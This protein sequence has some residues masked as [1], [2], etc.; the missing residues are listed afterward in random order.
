MGVTV[1]LNRPLARHSTLT[2]MARAVRR[3]FPERLKYACLWGSAK[4]DGQQVQRDHVLADRDIVE[5]H[6]AS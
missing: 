6:V 4:F 3:D 5:L 1:H 2:D